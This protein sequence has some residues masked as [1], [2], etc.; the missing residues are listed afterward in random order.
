MSELPAKIQIDHAA[1]SPRVL[2]YDEGDEPSW[3]CSMRQRRSAHLAPAHK[4]VP[5][6]SDQL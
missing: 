4:H 2:R 1:V 6:M 3:Q 5:A